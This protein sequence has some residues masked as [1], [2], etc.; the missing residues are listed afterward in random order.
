MGLPNYD[1]AA[2]NYGCQDC[3]KNYHNDPQAFPNDRIEFCTACI[4]LWFAKLVNLEQVYIIVPG[5][6]RAQ[7]TDKRFISRY[8]EAASINRLLREAQQSDPTWKFLGA[9]RLEVDNFNESGTM[10]GWLILPCI[11]LHHQHGKDC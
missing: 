4:G 7:R 3:G 10:L 1:L 8:G 9:R 5:L 11:V 2:Q 6:P